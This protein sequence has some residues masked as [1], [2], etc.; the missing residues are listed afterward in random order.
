MFVLK[1]NRL[2]I[3]LGFWLALLSVVVLF[4]SLSL[5]LFLL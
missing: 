2:N 5:L 1:R 3:Y 4:G